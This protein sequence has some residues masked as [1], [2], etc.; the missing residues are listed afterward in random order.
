M[1]AADPNP[2]F[3]A[4]TGAEDPALPL[5]KAQILTLKTAVSLP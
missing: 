4:V 2:G 1:C 3:A 5:P